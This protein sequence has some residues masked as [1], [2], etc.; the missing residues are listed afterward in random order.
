MKRLLVN[1]H[2]IIQSRSFQKTINFFIR[3][4]YLTLTLL[5]FLIFLIWPLPKDLFDYQYSTVVTDEN[6]DFLRVFT[7]NREQWIIPCQDNVEIPEKLKTCVVQYEDRFFY[8][9]PGINIGSLI[10]ATL[11]NIKKKEVVSGASTISMQLARL[12]FP[13]KRNFWNKAKEMG[14]AMR[15]ELKFNKS[16]I[17]RMYLSHAP[18]G[19]NIIGF[20]TASY[21][22]FGKSANNLTWSEAATLAVLPNAPGLVSPQADPEKLLYNR[23]RLLE[24]LN[25]QDIIDNDQLTLSKLENIP[26]GVY[27]FPFYAP[28][29]ARRLKAKKKGSIIETTINLDIQRRSEALLRQHMKILEYYGIKNGSVLIVDTQTGKVKAYVGSKDLFD[30]ESQ[31]HVDGVIASRSSGSLLKPF[32]YALSMDKGHIMPQS[33]IHDV[34][35]YYNAF[36]PNNADDQFRGLVTTKYALVHSL[37]VPAVRLL[38]SNG[39]FSF[40][41]FLK[42]AG[43][44]TLFRNPDEYGLPLIIGGAEVTLWDMV[45]MYRSLGCYGDFGKKINVFTN[46]GGEK[47]QLISEGA[48]YLTLEMLKELQ[49]PGHEYYWQL[50]EDKYPIAWKTG[51]SYGHKDAWAI[52]VTPKWT[53][54][55]W[56]GNFN[57]KG[58][59]NLGGAFSAGPLLFELLRMLPGDKSEWFEMPESAFKKSKLCFETGFTAGQYCD[60]VFETDVPINAPLLKLCPYHKPFSFDKDGKFEVCS[61]CWDSGH[62]VQNYLLYPPD[63]NYYLRYNGKNIHPYPV[64]NPKCEKHSMNMPFDL[65]YPKPGSRLWLPRDFGGVLQGFV[66]RVNHNVPTST[67]YWYIDNQ[68]LG[69]TKRIHNMSIKTEKGWHDLFLL[70]DMG[71]YIRARIQVDVRHQH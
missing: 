14:I 56:I 31:G 36:A 27:D 57:G 22:Y 68:Y 66:A 69:E 51:T 53:I 3:R 67:L 48:A 47:N 54:G 8:Y 39:N 25:E 20:Q 10:R 18:Y 46:E 4:K 7:N 23:N 59:K 32:L 65:V 5:T 40:Y 19:G 50:Y 30:V 13:A 9:H 70:D 29:L 35:S 28:H 60:S 16:D 34:P 42:E 43:V 1:F 17:L 21:K 52:G 41:S 12:R 15:M 71:N 62:F 6:N 11:Q 45:D 37:N 63:V 26:S 61:Y 24:L 33:L 2:N 58:N 55:V 44:S 49:R 64:H 38:F